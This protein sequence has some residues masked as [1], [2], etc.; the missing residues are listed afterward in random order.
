M[1]SWPEWSC[2]SDHQPLA[3]AEHSLECSA[4]HSFP[5]INDIPRFVAKSSYADHFGVQW[6]R[7]RRTQLDSNL[8]VPLARDRLRRCL[9]E[10]LWSTLSAKVVLEV[11]CGAGRFTEVLL[12]EGAR[13]VSVDLSSAVEANAQT[14]PCGDHHRV[15]QADLMNLP[16]RPGQF[17]AVLCLGVL[18][19]TPSPERSIAALRSHVARGGALIIDNYRKDF[20]WY[21]KTAPISRTVLKRLPPPSAISVTERLVRSLLPLHKMV[22]GHRI[23]TLLLYRLSPVMCYYADL[24]E[25]NDTH[26]FGLALLDTHDTLTDWY[27]H[28]RS[29]DQIR[30]VL[31]SLAMEDIWCEYGGNGVEARCTAPGLPS[32]SA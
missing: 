31:E 10:D 5:I 16:F 17:D 3:V 6:N 1:R 20:R 25:L 7:Y 32:P 14:F 22:V 11:G 28:L 18:Q 23:G 13:V 4:G 9:G 21:T 19:H 27:R 24:P 29:R 30:A 15:A 8:G 12:N 26:Q 2:P